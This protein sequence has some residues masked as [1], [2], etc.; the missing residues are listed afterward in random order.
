MES[1]SATR[2]NSWGRFC[3][4]R[5]FSLSKRPPERE[6]TAQ[7]LRVSDFSNARL[8]FSVCPQSYKV[9]TSSFVLN[10]AHFRPGMEGVVGSRIRAP[11][12]NAV[13]WFR[14]P[15]T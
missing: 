1:V 11:Y 15:G 14:T 4:E 13:I 8:Q 2:A 9:P 5:V 7:R 3:S 10:G 12:L 6:W